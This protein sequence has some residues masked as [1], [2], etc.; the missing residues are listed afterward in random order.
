VQDWGAV[1][2]AGAEGA[3]IAGGVVVAAVAI[4]AVATTVAAATTA[5]AVT[6]VVCADGDC[7]N[8]VTSAASAANGVAQA[9]N[10][11]GDPTN[12]VTAITKYY[13]PQMG[14][15]GEPIKTQFQK[16]DII[17]NVGGGRFFT[18]PGTPSS[19]ISLPYDKIGL[20]TDYYEVVKPF[21]VYAG[22]A[23]SWFGQPGLGTQY[24]CPTMSVATLTASSNNYIIPCP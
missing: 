23:L 20:P 24:F 8:E 21:T 16:G 13:P 9:L 19:S 11:D 15:A 14:F 3:L 12:E 4:A 18:L 1:A 7:T 17:A 22:P 2:E 6:G 10:A 5:A